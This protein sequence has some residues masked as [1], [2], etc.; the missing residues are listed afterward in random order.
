[1]HSTDIYLGQETPE[2]INK[3]IEACLMNGSKVETIA[4]SFLGTEKAKIIITKWEGAHISEL[5]EAEQIEIL[6]AYISELQSNI[7]SSRGSCVSQDI[8]K[9]MEDNYY[10]I[11]VDEYGDYLTELINSPGYQKV[12][13]HIANIMACFK[14]YMQEQHPEEFK[15]M[16]VKELEVALVKFVKEHLQ[17]CS[18]KE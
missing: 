18:E 11:D 6:I 1:M 10:G 3:D 13:H 17:V 4:K 2:S 9:L 16:S 14:Q 7:K 12:N 8:K 15:S 5:S